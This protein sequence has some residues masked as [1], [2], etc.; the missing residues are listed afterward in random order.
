MSP[1]PNKY[2]VTMNQSIDILQALIKRGLPQDVIQ[3]DFAK[4][5]KELRELAKVAADNT[6]PEYMQ[7]PRRT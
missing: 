7:C 2:L 4:T 6:P 1:T 3:G 5:I